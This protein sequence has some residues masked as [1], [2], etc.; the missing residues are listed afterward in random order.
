M[1]R[2]SRTECREW[3]YLYRGP[4]AQACGEPAI[5]VHR[6]HVRGYEN[7]RGESG[8]QHTNTLVRC[9]KT[10]EEAVNEE[11]ATIADL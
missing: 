2:I 4:S 5:G 11:D 6:K 8:F 10:D 3:D 1:S 7:G 9:H